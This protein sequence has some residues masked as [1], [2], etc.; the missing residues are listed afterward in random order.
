MLKLLVLMK[1]DTA[2]QREAQLQMVTAASASIPWAL[3][4]DKYS[5]MLP[6][7]RRGQ[8]ILNVSFCS[9][10]YLSSIPVASLS[11]IC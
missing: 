2:A 1:G 7:V 5:M 11:S 9:E 8:S 10:L 3:L 6:L 4:A